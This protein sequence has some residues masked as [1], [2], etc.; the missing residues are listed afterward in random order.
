MRRTA[1]SGEDDQYDVR[2]WLS[3]ADANSA[4]VV[5]AED[6]PQ[7]R[8]AL[9]LSLGVGF[10]V[11]ATVG[12]AAAAITAVLEHQPD[13][14]L[15]DVRMPGGGGARAAQVITDTCPEVRVV[16]ISAHEDAVTIAEMVTA[17]A[18]GYL[19]KDAPVDQMLD[20]L[21]RC[22]AGESV[23]TPALAKIVMRDHA[24]SSQAMELAKERRREREERLR[25]VCDPS[26]LSSV[27]QPIVNL[28]TRDVLM[29]EALS[30]FDTPHG[31]T[32]VE[33]FEEAVALDMSGELEL[34]ALARAVAA[35]KDHGDDTLN[36]SMNVSP[37]TL[38]NPAL[39][40]TIGAIASSRIVIE[41]TEY[42]RIV[43]YA[44]TKHA[45]ARLRHRGAR[46]A[47]D[48]AGAGFASLRHILDLAPDLIKLDISLVR[49]I[50]M[51]QPRRALATG[52][53]SFAREI[54]AEI[55]AE[56]IETAGELNC[57]YDLGVQY[58][59]GYVLAKPA[60]LQE[61][62]GRPITQLGTRLGMLGRTLRAQAS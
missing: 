1:S 25:E 62:A 52:L 4:T 36:V 44:E 49:G 24:K 34:A 55:V 57:L 11:V 15:L 5:I 37:E 6:D 18:C 30:R 50:D 51:D 17:G 32:T 19:M 7:T 20:T 9:A 53:I 16:A 40:A 35:L 47:I 10:D 13:L 42:A 56:G 38:L 28:A 29:Y 12:D 2:D 31:L 58:G 41:L 60:P 61:V 33:W 46:L 54:G 23:F 59:Q 27:F 21:R 8:A 26:V 39:A 43:D 48:D 45:I 14:A 22:A 3:P